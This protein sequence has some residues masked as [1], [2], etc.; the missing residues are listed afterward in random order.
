MWRALNWTS[1]AGMHSI[2]VANAIGQLVIE[3]NLEWAT[4]NIILL[5]AVLLLILGWNTLRW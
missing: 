5:I 4:L 3:L 1:V 2:V